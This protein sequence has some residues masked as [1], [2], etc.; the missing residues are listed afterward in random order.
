[1]FWPGER[2]ERERERF[3]CERGGQVDRVSEGGSKGRRRRRRLFFQSRA[4]MISRFFPHRASRLSSKRRGACS[5]AQKRVPSSLSRRSSRRRDVRPSRRAKHRG[6]S[7]KKKKTE[8]RSSLAPRPPPPPR[9][10]TGP[11]SSISPRKG[12][13]ERRQSPLPVADGDAKRR[14]GRRSDR[15]SGDCRGKRQRGVGLCRRRRA[16][17]VD[18][19]A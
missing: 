9:P 10:D 4:M 19:F 3:L 16:I 17:D 13:R 6:R 2:R 7:K 11:G 8:S 18:A 15:N 5:R 12:T 1:M 14:R